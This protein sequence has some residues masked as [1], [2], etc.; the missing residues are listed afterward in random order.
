MS[1]VSGLWQEVKDLTTLTATP[2]DRRFDQ[3]LVQ[4]TQ[5]KMV[6]KTMSQGSLRE[7]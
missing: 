2:F 1:V 4:K 3:V 5:K 6:K 7:V